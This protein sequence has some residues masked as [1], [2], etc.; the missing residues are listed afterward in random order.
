MDN[1]K[2]RILENEDG[3]SLSEQEGT[4]I[5]ETDEL[6]EMVRAFSENAPKSDAEKRERNKSLGEWGSGG[7]E[8]KKSSWRLRLRR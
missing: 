7:R 5:G 6:A 4:K 8:L 3:L 1:A 2:V